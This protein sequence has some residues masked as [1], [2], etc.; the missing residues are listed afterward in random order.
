MRQ[1]ADSTLLAAA[2]YREADHPLL[3]IR[4]FGKGR[5]LCWMTDIGPHWMSKLFLSDPSYGA[6]MR[7]MVEWLT[8]L[9]DEG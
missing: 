9:R 6:L 4:H 1:A 8:G 3:A 7:S 5:S 2:S